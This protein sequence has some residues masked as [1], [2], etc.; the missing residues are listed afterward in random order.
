M[1]DNGRCFICILGDGKR[2]YIT[3]I[4]DAFKNTKRLVMNNHKALSIA[5]TSCRIVNWEFFEKEIAG[6]QLVI[7]KE[8][9]STNIPE[10]DESMCA[11]LKKRR[12][13]I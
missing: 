7:E 11:I 10:F 12:I 2:E 4:N 13:L 9:I 8:W 1:T 3:D 5:T 6:N